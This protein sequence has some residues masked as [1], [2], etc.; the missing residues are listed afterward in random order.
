MRTTDDEAFAYRVNFAAR[1]IAEGRPTTRNFD[2]C[3]EMWDSDEVA[4]M[5]YRRSLSN[6]KIAANIWRYLNRESVTKA[7]EQL[8][9]IASRDMARQAAMTRSKVAESRA[10]A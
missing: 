6:P 4:T 1:V 9:H 8:A 10:N 2:N 7:A 3:F 5:V